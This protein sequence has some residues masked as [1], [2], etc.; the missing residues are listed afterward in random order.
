NATLE[1]K[2]NASVRVWSARKSLISQRAFISALRPDTLVLKFPNAD[3]KSDEA[4]TTIELAAFDVDSLQVSIEGTWTPVP[5]PLDLSAA[6]Q[7]AVARARAAI[8][9]Q[10]VTRSSAITGTV[11]DNGKPVASATVHAER[12]DDARAHD[13]PRPRAHRAPPE[14][15]R[16]VEPHRARAGRAQGSALGQRARRCKR[17]SARRRIDEPSGTRRRL[18][19][20]QRGLDRRARHSR[21]RCRRR[22]RQLPGRDHQRDHEDG[23]E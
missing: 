23:H 18:S 21:T 7:D 13:A 4:W 20:A 2:R 3:V 8:A 1:V 10:P 14:R 19:L 9:A 15:T 22:A 16:R 6:A 17:L 11:L 12:R 5:M